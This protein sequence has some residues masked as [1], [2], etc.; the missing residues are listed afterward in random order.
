LQNKPPQTVTKEVV[1]EKIVT[2]E[3]PIG[4]DDLSIG[5]L[6]SEAFKKLFKIK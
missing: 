2:K 1:V 6:L 4:F 5:E 3:V